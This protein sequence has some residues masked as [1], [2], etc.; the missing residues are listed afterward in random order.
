MKGWV[1]WS[2]ILSLCACG[3]SRTPAPAH[4]PAPTTAPTPQPKEAHLQPEKRKNSTA[5]KTAATSGHTSPGSSPAGAASGCGAFGPAERLGKISKRIREAS[6][7]VLSQRDPT[8]LWTHNDGGDGRLYGLTLPKGKVVAKVSLTGPQ[9]LAIDWEE[10]S[11]GPC[12]DKLGVPSKGTRCLV[13]GDIGDNHDS[14][15]AISFHR[16]PEP[17]PRGGRQRVSRY[18]TMRARFPK[19]PHDSE[20]FVMDGAG[21]IW[22]WTKG[23]KHTRLYRSPFVPGAGKLEFIKKI[24]S[25]R[26]MGMTSGRGA[27]LTA[28]AWDDHSKRLLLRSYDAVWELCLGKA[29][30]QAMPK[31]TWKR[32]TVAREKQGEAIALGGGGFFHLSEGKRPHIYRVPRRK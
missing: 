6:G 29:G 3:R 1:W 31:A 8:V 11:D 9:A 27:R 22:L 4:P 20:A 25:A 13:I 14:R 24:K 26:A 18:E 30:L 7:L 15:M 2:L 21:V 12:G 19:K 10:L 16:L 5:K 17:N 28:A 23:D 32:V